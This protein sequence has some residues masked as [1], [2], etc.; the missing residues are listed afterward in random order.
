MDDMVSKAS[1]AAAH[2]A[3]AEH[4][5]KLAGEARAEAERHRKMKEAYLK[6]GAA[7]IGKY[8]L[9]E[10]CERLAK[11]FDEVAAQNEMLAKAHQEMA[12]AGGK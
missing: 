7:E 10:H 9:D 5:E 12:K 3:L 4:Y 1:T 2:Q 6:R 11:S 8:H